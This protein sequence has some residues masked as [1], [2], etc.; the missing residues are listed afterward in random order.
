MWRRSLCINGRHNKSF[1]R[2]ANSAA[3]IEN[4]DGFQVVCA[5]G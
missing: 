3:L 1:N 4:L 2:N 5:P